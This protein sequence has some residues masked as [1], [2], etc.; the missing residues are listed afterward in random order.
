M[1]LCKLNTLKSVLVFLSF[2]VYCYSKTLSNN[3]KDLTKAST[4]YTKEY[5][6][7]YDNLNTQCSCYK[8]F[9]GIQLIPFR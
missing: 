8:Q 9:Q 7:N 3:L 2:K 5:F 6:S 4:L 1:Y